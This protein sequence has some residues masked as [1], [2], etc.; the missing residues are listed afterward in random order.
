MRFAILLLSVALG[1]GGCAATSN[2][3]TIGE[4]S[5]QQGGVVIDQRLTHVQ[6]I[7]DSLSVTLPC[8][9]RYHVLNNPAVTA[10]SWPGGEIFLSAGLIDSA[11]DDEIAAAIAHELGHLVNDARRPGAV[12]LR[13]ADAPLALE[14]HA[15]ATG[16]ALLVA[17]GRPPGALITL[18]QKVCAANPSAACRHDLGARIQLLQNTTTR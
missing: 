12:G 14:Q 2:I 15:D 6:A 18:L 10:Y 8:S 11:S 5:R 9:V 16:E 3:A 13:G 1:T 4:W 7:G 17:S